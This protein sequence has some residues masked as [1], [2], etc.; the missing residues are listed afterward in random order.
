MAQNIYDNQ[1]F[2]DGYTQLPRQVRGLAGAPEWGMTVSMLSKITD[3]RVADLGCGFGWVSRWM[4]ENG[5][6]SVVG[7]DLSK[8]MIERAMKETSD[9]AIEYQI[10]DLET[11]ELPGN[12]FDLAYSSLTFHY[13]QDFKRLVKAIYRSLV[14]GG[15]FV[16]SIEHPIY[17]A[18]RNPNWIADNGNYK[19]WPVNRY[20]VEGERRTDWFAKGIVKFHRTMGTTLNTLIDAG[21]E[22]LRVEEFSPTKE[23]I[24]LE[25]GLAEEMERPMIL[26][27]S[28]KKK[29]QED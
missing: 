1:T 4:R 2:F 29:L 16:F 3:K 5:A 21:F 15:D 24:E 8:K 22:I 27:I 13:I 26:L 11:L 25:P 17:M 28:A 12:S 20:S 14:E 9:N 6:K 18:A 7:Y 19:T 23:Q 10:A